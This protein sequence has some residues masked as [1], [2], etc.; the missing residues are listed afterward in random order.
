ML[1]MGYEK[2]GR[3]DMVFVDWKKTY[4][5]TDVSILWKRRDFRH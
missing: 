2:E 3:G 1:T 5:V 4:L